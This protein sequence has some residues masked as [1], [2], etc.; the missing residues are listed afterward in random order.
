MRYV[1][2][3]HS[4]DI[5]ENRK[6]FYKM[7]LDTDMLFP[8]LTKEWGRMGQQKRKKFSIFTSSDL[9]CKEWD[10]TVKKRIRHGYRVSKVK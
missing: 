6:R 5:F 1:I 2:R 9:A 7:I 10:R 8:V 4:I 3:L